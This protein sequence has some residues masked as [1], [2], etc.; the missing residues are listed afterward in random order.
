MSPS[1]STTV[2]LI[3]IRSFDD[4]KSRLAGAL[5]PSERCRLSEWMAARVVEAAGSL[6]TRIVT[7]D[8]G[9]VEWAHSRQVGVMTVGR[10]GLNASVTAAVEHAARVGFE[11]AIIAHADLP[12][13]TDLSVVDHAGV[14][15]APD[16]AHDGS[17]VMCVPTGAGFVF[18]YGPESFNRH[19]AEAERLGLALT[20][21]DDEQLAWDV[22]DPAD[23]PPDWT[24]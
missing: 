14:C 21:I 3:P 13:A 18:A 10:Q 2:V 15:I 11:R 9:V 4:S 24:P 17:N 6:P 19:R 20:I 7:D 1:D 23:L 16:R 8:S 5:D 12:A 22:D